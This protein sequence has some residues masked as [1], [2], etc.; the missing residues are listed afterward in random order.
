MTALIE[1]MQ[2][3]KQLTETDKQDA[4]VHTLFMCSY[5]IHT[6]FM[7]YFFGMCRAISCLQET[8]IQLFELYIPVDGCVAVKSS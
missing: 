3:L 8:H 6:L 1:H 2:I 4:N 5:I 7:K